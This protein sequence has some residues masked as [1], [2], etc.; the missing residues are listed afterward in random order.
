M[1]LALMARFT[2]VI[3]PLP[4]ATTSPVVLRARVDTPVG[5]MAA[6]TLM[7]PKLLPFSAPIRKV[8]ADTRFSSV[9]VRDRRSDTSV[10]RSITVLPEYGAI[11]TTP[12]A[13]V[14]PMVA[15]SASLFAVNEIAEAAETLLSNEIVAAV[16]VIATEPEVEVMSAAVAVEMF[17]DPEIEI[18]PEAWSAPVGA[19][20]VPPLIRTVPASAVKAPAPE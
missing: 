14:V 1:K 3:E 7:L 20:V 5:A 19:T 16:E 13:D 2:S 18:L 15:P 11:V 12:L 9:L 17:P 4:L 6:V 10:P 8:P